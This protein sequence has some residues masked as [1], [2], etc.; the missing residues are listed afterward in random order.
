[1]GEFAPSLRTGGGFWAKRTAAFWRNA[2]ETLW[3]SLGTTERIFRF[4]IY[5]LWP[6]I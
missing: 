2:L 3:K 5:L 1:M 6:P 4:G